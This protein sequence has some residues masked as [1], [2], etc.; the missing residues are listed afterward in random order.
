M[1][2]LWSTCQRIHF[3][4]LHTWKMTINSTNGKLVRQTKRKNQSYSSKT[5]IATLQKDTTSIS[6]FWTVTSIMWPNLSVFVGWFFSIRH[7]ICSITTKE[8]FLVFNSK[9]IL[10][11][12]CFPSLSLYNLRNTV[13]WMLERH[14]IWPLKLQISSVYIGKGKSIVI[15]IY[16]RITKNYLMYMKLCCNQVLGNDSTIRVNI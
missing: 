1:G 4:I 2:V 3:S 6:L 8:S 10:R 5:L 14:W 13:H 9:S 16:Q 12:C 11:I 15:Y 7:K